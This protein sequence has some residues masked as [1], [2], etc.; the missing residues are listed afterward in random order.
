M[1]GVDPL[2]AFEKY[3]P[4]PCLII[5]CSDENG[6]VN[7]MV[8]SWNMKCSKNPPLFAIS[9]GNKRYTKSL[10]EESK[11]FVIAVPNKEMESLVRF[12]GENSGRDVDKH[13]FLKKHILPAYK[14]K[15]PLLSDATVNMECRLASKQ[16]TGDHTIYVGQVINAVINPD[17]NILLSLPKVNGQR[18]FESWGKV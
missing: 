7:G 12:L 13:N 18:C 14:I 3:K 11:E 16:V 6:K 5:L 1:K 9:I 8:A 15:T 10:I 17:K 2:E 4:E